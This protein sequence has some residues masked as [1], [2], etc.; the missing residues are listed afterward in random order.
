MDLLHAMEKDADHASVVR[1]TKWSRDLRNPVR[2]RCSNTRKLLGVISSMSQIASLVRS[3][4]L[5][6]INTARRASGRVSMAVLT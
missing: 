5:H 3:L 1:V 6:K 2:A 4:W